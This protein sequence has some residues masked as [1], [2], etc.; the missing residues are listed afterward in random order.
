MVAQ[1]RN[2]SNEEFVARLTTTA[3]QVALR[4][5]IKGS[6]ADLY[7][8]LWKALRAEYERGATDRNGTEGRPTCP[9]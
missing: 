5:G 4:Q 3:Y 1:A 7:L 9:R 2:D 6:F 8:N